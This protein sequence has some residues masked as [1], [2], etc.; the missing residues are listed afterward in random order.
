MAEADEHI[1]VLIEIP[2]VKK[3]HIDLTVAPDGT[4][5]SIRGQKKLA[6]DKQDR[7]YDCA[8]RL[9]GEFERTVALPCEVNQDDVKAKLHNGVLQIE[10][11]KADAY[12]KGLKHI[13]INAT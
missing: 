5:L 12:A 8:E 3:K 2:G 13:N 4:S 1:H 6:K 11:T 7:R 9:Y 10:L